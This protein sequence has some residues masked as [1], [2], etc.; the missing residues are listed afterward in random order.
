MS[1]R[2]SLRRAGY[3][4]AALLMITAAGC[5][6]EPSDPGQTADPGGAA[7]PG[8]AATADV[9]ASGAEAVDVCALLTTD[10]VTPV[11][12]T[13]DGGRGGDS[14]GDGGSCVWENP[15]TYH[16]I[17]VSIGDSGTAANGQLPAESDYGQTEPGP[18]GIRFAP[19]NIA[20]FVVGDRGCEIQVVTSVTDDSDRPDIVRLIGLVRER[21]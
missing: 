8:P 1:V 7:G 6:S 18:D 11:I 5:G 13:N 20:E 21:V 12:G 10:E 14:G 3:V 17:T 15:E 9:P 19:G 4:L 2:G 16:S